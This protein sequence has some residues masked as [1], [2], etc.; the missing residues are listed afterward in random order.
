M[1]EIDVCIVEMSKLMENIYRDVNIFL[2]NELIK[3]CNNLNINVLDVI[4]MVNKYLC[5]NIY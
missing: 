2:V 4:E 5:V 3:I 1:I